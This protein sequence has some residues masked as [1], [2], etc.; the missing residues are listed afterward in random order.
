MIRPPG[1]RVPV[2]GD[3]ENTE[4]AVGPRP[5]DLEDDGGG[6]GVEVRGRLVGEEVARL[7]R[8]A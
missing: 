5:E 1:G 7:L 2:V 4:A 3:G 8:Q 6:I